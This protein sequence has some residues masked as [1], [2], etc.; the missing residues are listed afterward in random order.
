MTILCCTL[1]LL[2]CTLLWLLHTL[3]VSCYC[4]NKRHVKDVPPGYQRA[5]RDLMQKTFLCVLCVCVRFN[6]V[7][8]SGEVRLW[9]AGLVQ[10]TT[11]LC[12]DA[13]KWLNQL[14]THGGSCTL[15]ALQVPS[16]HT[17]LHH[18]N[19]WVTTSWHSWFFTDICFTHFAVYTCFLQTGC[20]FEDPVALYLISDGR[21]DSSHSLI[22]REIDTLRQEKSLTIHTIAVN[23]H[24]R[25]C[26]CMSV[27][28]TA[29]KSLFFS[30]CL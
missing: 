5:L 8:F 21:S 17:A 29:P 4:N 3:Q 7:V 16:T 14:S 26:C 13:V 27:L 22:L 2:C 9:Q 20:A 30:S 25:W 10:S 19:E 12:K 23:S 1:W 6:M 15:Q 24:D 11:D 28:H 18:G